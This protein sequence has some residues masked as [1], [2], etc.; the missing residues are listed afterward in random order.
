[1]I[2]FGFNEFAVAKFYNNNSSNSNNNNYDSAREIIING[3]NTT[4]FNWGLFFLN[5]L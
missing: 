2:R 1:M 4:R 3:I 5:K